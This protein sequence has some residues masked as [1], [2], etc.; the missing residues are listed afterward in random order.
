VRPPITVIAVVAVIV[1]VLLAILLVG[2]PDSYLVGGGLLL[3]V[4][5]LGLVR[6]IWFAWLFLT[7]VA[8]GDL[9]NAALTWPAWG[10]LVVNGTL[11]ILLV[12]PSTRRHVRPPRFL[13]HRPIG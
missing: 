6:G 1:G 10:A 9:V 2:R 5:S 3:L 7:V 8:V 11:L 12:A 4:A 13:R